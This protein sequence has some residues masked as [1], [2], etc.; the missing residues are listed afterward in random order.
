MNGY[1]KLNVQIITL[2]IKKTDEIVL[3]GI[4][5]MYFTAYS[6]YTLTLTQSEERT[7]GWMKSVL[8]QR[9]TIM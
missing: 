1:M 8:S 7:W 6:T 3:H 2:K 5:Y 9:A 4:Q